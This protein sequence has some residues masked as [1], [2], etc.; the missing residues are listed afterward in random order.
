MYICRVF[1]SQIIAELT[2]LVRMAKIRADKRSK[3]ERAQHKMS[4]IYNTSLYQNVITTLLNVVG[5]LSYV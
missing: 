2:E 1:W 5:S 3:F 4:K